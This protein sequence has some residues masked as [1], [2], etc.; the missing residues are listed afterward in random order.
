MTRACLN[1]PFSFYC[2][3]AHPLALLTLHDR[4]CS[5]KM[6][7]LLLFICKERIF[8]NSSVYTIFAQKRVCIT[9]AVEIRVHIIISF[10]T[11][12]ITKVDNTNSQPQSLT[13]T[14]RPT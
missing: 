3:H 8:M 10:D 11:I 4:N 7:T 13:H 5:V 2:V 14:Q 1:Q 6:S 12:P 9:L